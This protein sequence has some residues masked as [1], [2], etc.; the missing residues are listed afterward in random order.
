M[1]QCTFCGKICP[2]A[3]RLRDHL[4][5]HTGDK[6][7]MCAEC[8]NQFTRHE[9]LRRHM[10]LH[11]GDKPFMCNRCACQFARA[12][13]LRR[14]LQ[15]HLIEDGQSASSSAVVAEEADIKEDVDDGEL[16]YD[17]SKY[18]GVATSAFTVERIA[19]TEPWSHSSIEDD[20]NS[21]VKSE[22][23][24]FIDQLSSSGGC[25]VKQDCGDDDRDVP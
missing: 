24:I 19:A 12:D 2:D 9:H 14:H 7:F 13:H 18:G 17:C 6:P 25:L 11:S 8:G 10:R 23:E 15:A 22:E 5:V 21:K 4:R 16:A 3:N 1:L 20:D